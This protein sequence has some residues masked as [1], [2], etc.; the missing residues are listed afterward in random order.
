M[1]S[2]D[3]E[4]MTEQSGLSYTRSVSEVHFKVR[5]VP[6]K[7]QGPERFFVQK[8]AAAEPDNIVQDPTSGS[9]PKY[10]PLYILKSL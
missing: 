2:S 3:P 10:R 6:T 8:T 5:G 4:F 9:F 7:L 1:L